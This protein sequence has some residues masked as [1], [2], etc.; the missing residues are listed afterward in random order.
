MKL[1]FCGGADEVGASCTLVE[2]AGKRFLI[3]CGIRQQPKRRG[4]LPTFK[5]VLASGGVEAIIVTHG[6]IDHIGALPY[7]FALHRP[8]PIY[9]S[10]PTADLMSILL[11]DSF[12]LSSEA[13]LLKHYGAKFSYTR[14]EIAAVYSMLHILPMNRP[15]PICD[16]AI[17]ATLF[18][19]GHILGAASV[20]LES[21]KE[22]A[23]FTGDISLSDQLTVTGSHLPDIRPDVI[24]AESTYGDTVRESREQQEAQLLRQ[25]QQVIDNNGSILFPVFAIG[26]AQEITLL[27]ASAMERGLIERVPV[28]VDG[29]ARTVCGVYRR[30]CEYV[31]PWFKQRIMTGNPYPGIQEIKR[32][33]HRQMAL[34]SQPAIFISSSG[35]LAGG[36]SVYY[37][38]AL[39]DSPKNMIAFTGYQDEE[40]PGW[41]VQRIQAGHQVKIGGEKV[42]FNCGV[43]T[44]SLSAHADKSEL[45]E[46]LSRLNPD[47]KSDIV[48][49][50]G[51]ETARMALSE[52]LQTDGH[53]CILPRLNGLVRTAKR[54]TA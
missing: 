12:Q 32:H 52:E 4:S 20:L 10:Q 46:I 19:S 8:V 44:Y 17:N 18:P 38:K 51:G 22:S 2:L 45:T 42:T 29:M 47:R 54:I 48:L 40:S 28:V 16:G 33:V 25:V 7:F 50:H 11:E 1:T 5:K 37:A 26:R 39:A 27:L 6:H 24:I 36:P 53:H 9:V 34:E 15:R 43:C 35:M 30:H 21:D 13:P 41:I 49:V 23:L 14:Q 3:D 31:S